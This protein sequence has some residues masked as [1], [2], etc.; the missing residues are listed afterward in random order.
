MIDLGTRRFERDVLS[1]FTQSDFTHKRPAPELRVVPPEGGDGDG[2]VADVGSRPLHRTDGTVDLA[3]QGSRPQQFG[4]IERNDPITTTTRTCGA[5]GCTEAEHPITLYER[6]P[7][8][9]QYRC[10]ACAQ[11]ALEST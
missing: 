6:A 5:C 8:A 9:G 3:V 1:A 4:L 2:V 11:A 7:L 10:W